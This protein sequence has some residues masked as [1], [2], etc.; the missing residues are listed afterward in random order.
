MAKN[1]FW[2]TFGTI[3]YCACQWLMTIVVVRFSDNYEAAGY[4]SLAMTTSSSF[5]AITLF[6]MRNFQVSDVRSE[7]SSGE[8]VGSRFLTCALGLV[9]CIVYS[10]ATSS[11]Y[12]MLCVASFMLIRVAEGLVD[13]LHGIN[14]KYDRYD[15][16]GISYILRGVITILAFSI[17]L[18]VK[19]QVFTALI[20]TA[21][22]NLLIALLWDWFRTSS[23]EKLSPVFWNEQVKRLLIACVPIVVFSFL[24][25]VENLFPKSIS[26]PATIRPTR[27]PSRSS[28]R[29]KSR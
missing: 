29:R 7:Y 4:L 5:S 17:I 28:P 18:Y 19:D 21:I 14:Q 11:V 3:F 20:V 27:C 15:Y 22:L 25:S 8:Y 6:S 1:V 16:I 26:P 12:Q 24:L 9:L 2:N 23:L 13:V 10:A